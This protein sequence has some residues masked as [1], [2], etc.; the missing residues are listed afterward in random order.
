MI[1]KECNVQFDN[2]LALHKHLRSHKMPIAYYFQKHFPRYDL[3]DGSLI[4][5]KSKDYYF[6]TN[7]NN[8]NNFSKWLS[9]ASKEDCKK[10]II[11]FLV[12]RKNNKKIIYAPTQVELKTLMC[13]GMK[14]INDLFGD[15]YQLTNSLGFI[16]KFKKYKLDSVSKLHHN[17]KIIIDSREQKSLSFANTEING[18]KF[19]DYKL[20]YED[21]KV[22]IERKAV[23]DFFST[24]GFQSERFIKEIERSRLEGYYMIIVTEGTI[25]DVNNYPFSSYLR[26][27]IKISPE[28]VF[29]TVREISQKYDSIQF[30]FVKNRSESERVIKKIF[31]CS[32]EIKEI[33]CQYIY[34]IKEL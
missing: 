27:K 13:P 11:D 29:Y 6:N 20:K 34:D 8:R 26:N 16:N 14:Y 17:K 9:K 4:K 19:G 5:F 24:F 18:L 30:L 23:G 32:G 22:V 7:F 25:S 33:D 10:Y 15:Y 28:V 2:E 1:C 12:K 31:A 3:Y 21:N